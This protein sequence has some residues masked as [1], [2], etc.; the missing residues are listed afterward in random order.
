[1]A[2]VHPNADAN[3]M[4]LEKNCA[5]QTD[6]HRTKAGPIDSIMLRVISD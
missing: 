1:M 4:R 6:S 3:K 5:S 2:R